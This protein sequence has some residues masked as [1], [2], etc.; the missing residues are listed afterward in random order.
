MNSIN[1]TNYYLSKR[2]VV[3]V[4]LVIISIVAIQFIVGMYIPASTMGSDDYGNLKKSIFYSLGQFSINAHGPDRQ[5]QWGGLLYP[6]YISGWKIFDDFELRIRAVFF[7]NSLLAAGTVFVSTLTIYSMTKYRSL[8]VPFC[9]ATLGPIFLMTYCALT[10]NLLYFIISLSAFS[11]MQ[12]EKKQNLF[13]YGIVLLCAIAAPLTRPPGLACSVGIV[14]AICFAS[15]NQRIKRFVLAAIIL[16]SCVGLY[17]YIS[18]LFSERLGKSREGMYISR[19]FSKIFSYGGISWVV[20]SF[21]SQLSY[22]VASC[23]IIPFFGFLSMLGVGRERKDSHRLSVEIYT[24][25]SALFFI[26]FAVLHLTLKLRFNPEQTDFI[27]GRYSDPALLLFCIVGLVYY[28]NYPVPKIGSKKGI[29]LIALGAIAIFYLGL[30]VIRCHS[31]TINIAGLYALSYYQLT[32]WHLILAL[33]VMFSIYL[34]SGKWRITLSLLVL[35]LFNMWTV[36][37]GLDG[38]GARARRIFSTI[39]VNFYIGANIPKDEL[40]CFDS[41]IASRNAPGAHFHMRDVYRILEFAVYPRKTLM[42]RPQN[43]DQCLNLL[44]DTSQ[45]L[46]QGWKAV[47]QD[48]TYLFAAREKS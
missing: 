47:W 36:Y 16:A 18:A 7:L 5:N 46:P 24:L 8:L 6:L 43:I 34:F 12:Y 39:G 48:R 30:F 4:F 9:F 10:E 40:I 21:I 3:A 44:T 25:I 41:R 22:V 11:V 33:I 31:H 23:A 32:I 17:L 14:T 13:W 28:F 15:S 27:Y 20:E 45:P 42:V 26:C 2:D 29:L 37:E 38:Q 1:P 19:F 35:V